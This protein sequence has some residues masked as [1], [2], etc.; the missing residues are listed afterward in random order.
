MLQHKYLPTRVL[1]THP[2]EARPNNRQDRAKTP[3][4]PPHTVIY[5]GQT[6]AAAHYGAAAFSSQLSSRIRSL[7]RLP[8]QVRQQRGHQRYRHRHGASCLAPLPLLVQ[9]RQ[10]RFDFLQISLDPGRF[11]RDP[12]H[13]YIVEQGVKAVAGGEQLLL[14]AL[15]IGADLLVPHDAVVDDDDHGL[16][17]L[18]GR[19]DDLGPFKGV[20]AAAGLLVDQF[21]R[22]LHYLVVAVTDD[23]VRPTPGQ[24]PTVGAGLVIL[25]HSHMTAATELRHVVVLGRTQEAALLLHRVGRILGV[26]AVAGVAGDAVLL[27]DASLP[28]LDRLAVFLRHGRMAGDTDDLL[29]PGPDSTHDHHSGHEQHDRNSALQH[30]YPPES[31]E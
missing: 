12:L 6:K 25:Q 31:H 15:G 5:Y 27:V 28:E 20:A 29:G 2:D 18:H 8:H 11:V 26:A 7:V 17:L 13:V 30:I 24:C 19:P 23:A 16:G 4:S 21:Q 3:P 10:C 14:K 22:G 1:N 9:R